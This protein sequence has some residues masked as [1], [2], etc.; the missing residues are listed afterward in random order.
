MMKLPVRQGSSGTIVAEVRTRL[1]RLGFLPQGREGSDFDADTDLAVR[2]FQQRRGIDVDGIVGVDTFKQLE[3]ARW[4]LGDRVLW[5]SAAHPHTGD[6]VLTL[7]KRLN[8]LG[9]Q[10]GQANGVFG[11][12][13]D[14][15]LRELQRNVGAPVDGTCGRN[16]LMA[17]ERIR[18]T[19]RGGEP[20]ALWSEHLHRESRTGITDKIIVIDA[21]HGG[22]LDPGVELNGL[23]EAGISEDLA[24]R[25]EGRLAA[26]GT[27]VLMTR[28]PGH[29]LDRMITEQERAQIA[30]DVDA[31]LVISLH[32]NVASPAAH[33]V[34]TYYY[35]SERNI[36]VL[37]RR[38]AELVQSELVSRT[39]LFDCRTHA[40]SWDLLRR[41]R[42]T[43]VRCE[44]GYLSHV[45]DAAKL[46]EARFRDRVAEAIAAAAVAF[47]SP[48]EPTAGDEER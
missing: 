21:G 31:D 13:T 35:G 3:E 9:F 10:V 32:A 34:T 20:V 8:E 40:M 5:Y 18:R 26:I 15:A 12:G 37:G 23:S 16:T 29:L 22:S 47:F 17:L 36:S 39:D 42:S 4:Q 43:T 19:H 45:G 28:P 6:D 30:N 1:V 25:L 7:Q 48:I 14:A 24:N 11:V 33:G 27:Q 46:R 38:F 2:A 41:T 44:I